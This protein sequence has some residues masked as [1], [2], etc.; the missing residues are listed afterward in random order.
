MQSPESVVFEFFLGG[1]DLLI[2]QVLKR[3]W[4]FL[5][6]EVLL[7]SEKQTT[8][9]EMVRQLG[10]EGGQEEQ[11]VVWGPQSHKW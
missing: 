7:A 9:G 5:K 10:P 6:S 3:D 8:K 11:R 1:S 2:R 4:S